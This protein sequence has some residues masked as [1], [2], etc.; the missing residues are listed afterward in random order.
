MTFLFWNI[1]K[2]PVLGT[3]RALVDEHDVDVL[4]LVELAA[5][6]VDVLD[7]L[8]P[9]RDRVFHMPV[10][11]SERVHVFDRLPREFIRG[12]ADEDY[13]TFVEILPPA[14]ASALVAA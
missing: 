12:V 6:R 11:F 8:N 13:L 2:Q 1:K 14:G 9:Q 7:A 10:G 4:V 5:T 3:V